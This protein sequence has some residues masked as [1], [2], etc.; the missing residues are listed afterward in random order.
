MGEEASFNKLCIYYK[1]IENKI[2]VLLII[3]FNI[4]RSMSFKIN[5]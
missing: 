4:S 5:L 2:P 3:C 1:A